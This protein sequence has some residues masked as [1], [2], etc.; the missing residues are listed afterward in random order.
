MVSIRITKR[1]T[2]EYSKG[3]SSRPSTRRRILGHAAL[4]KYAGWL[5]ALAILLASAALS[6]VVHHKTQQQAEQRFLYRAEQ[7]RS[8]I[9]FRMATHAQILRGATALFAAS[10]AVSRAEWRD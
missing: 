4:T 10:N 3:S 2:V 5:I 7:E 8:K 9:L 6:A 1:S